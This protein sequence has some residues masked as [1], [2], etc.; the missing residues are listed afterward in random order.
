[1]SALR[2]IQILSSSALDTGRWDACVQQDPEAKVYNYSAFLNCFASGWHGLILGD[3]EA[4]L[5]LTG[6][7]RLGARWLLKPPF[8]QQF[9]LSVKGQAP[10]PDEQQAMLKAIR[11]RFKLIRYT[12]SAGSLFRAPQQQCTNYVL[13]L[14]K[15]YEML[16]AG[17]TKSGRKNIRKAQEGRLSIEEQI[18]VEKVIEL[19]L[20]AYGSLSKLPKTEYQK[21]LLLTQQQTPYFQCRT[22][23]VYTTEGSLIF[24]ALLLQDHQSLYYVLGAPTEEGRKARA[25]YYFI[26]YIIEQHAGRPLKL[27][28]EGS[29]LKNVAD[30]YLSFGPERELYD[31]IQEHQYR[32]PAS[33]LISR[34]TGIH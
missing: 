32:F 19:Y 12:C 20:H 4:C 23:G 2:T 8:I 16:Q 7:K 24:A 14:N 18:P 21:F 22:F 17:F 27:D 29:D 6:Y 25:T 9:H 1:M 10:S 3:Y 30:F 11:A 34:L 5:P 26:N 15:P 13:P 33:L 31:Y 28:F